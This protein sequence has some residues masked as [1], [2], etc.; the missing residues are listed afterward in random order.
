MSPITILVLFTLWI[1]AVLLTYVGIFHMSPR[2]RAHSN[3]SVA[4]TMLLSMAYSIAF[5]LFTVGYGLSLLWG[6][7]F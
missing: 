3:K 5:P 4:A 2:E 6:K 7:L 1:L